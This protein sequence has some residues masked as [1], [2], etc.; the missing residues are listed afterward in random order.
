M[1]LSGL[2]FKEYMRDNFNILEALLVLL[3]VVEEAFQLAQFD[4]N[5]GAFSALRALR[6]LRVFRLAR[7]WK[8]LQEL[9][10][11]L[12]SSIKEIGTFSILLL[13]SIVIFL[14]LGRELFAYQI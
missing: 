13:I 2:G 1:K 11:R 7:S 10:A 6:L 5:S 12:E 9:I 14:L 3:G 4:L 8:K